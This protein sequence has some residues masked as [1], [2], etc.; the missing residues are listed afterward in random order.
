MTLTIIGFYGAYPP[1]NGATS[2]YLI[3]DGDTKVLLDCGS[4][5]LSKLQERVALSALDGVVLT[6]YHPDH[7]ADLGCLQY[8]AMIDTQLGRRGKDFSAWGP[9]ELSRLTYAPYCRGYSYEEAPAFKIGSLTFTVSRNIHDVTCYA[10]KVADARGAT[11][12]YSGD[13]G[14]SP[15][16]AEFSHGVDCLICEASFYKEQAG[17]A[18]HHLTAAQA[19][20]IAAAAE[21]RRLVL[22]HLPHFGELEQLTIQAEEVYNGSVALATQWMKV[23]LER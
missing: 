1:P 4:G 18:A 23:K 5:V 14:Y 22:T 15:A 7:C 6:H 11:L 8:A 21:V 9:G 13:T 12:V 17:R 10:V 20:R 19:G 2:G 16:L 3:E